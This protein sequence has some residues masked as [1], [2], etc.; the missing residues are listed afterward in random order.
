MPYPLF[1]NVLLLAPHLGLLTNNFRIH[2]FWTGTLIKANYISNA[3]DKTLWQP[4]F[5][6]FLNFPYEKFLLCLNICEY[7]EW[8]KK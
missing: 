1:L 8:N 5:N 7:L 4:H 6:R 2:R 3:L